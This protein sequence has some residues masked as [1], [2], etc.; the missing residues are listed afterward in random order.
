[1]EQS[2]IIDGLRRG[3]CQAWTVFYD[4]YYDPVCGRVARLMGGK[5]HDVADVVQDTFLAAARAAAQFDPQRGSLWDWV[6][7]IAR[8]RV[9]LHF[10]KQER[11]QRAVEKF[12]GHSSQ[13]TSWLN[14]DS[15]QPPDA[16]ETAELAVLVRAT[17]GDLPQDYGELLAAKYLDGASIESLAEPTGATVSAI[18][19]RLARARTAFRE[20][21]ERM[22]GGV[23]MQD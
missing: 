22:A 20:A 10:R 17:L 7:G 14:G 1:M 3:H 4:T 5:T 9:A 13:V 16:A 19:S 11:I 21:F 8:N 12:S 2:E 18:P 15:A 23:V 6:W